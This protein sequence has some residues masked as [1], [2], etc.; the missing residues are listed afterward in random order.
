MGE[1]GQPMLEAIL[2]AY[3]TIQAPPQGECR[4]FAALLPVL[5]KQY[6]EAPF[7]R[8]ITE[9]GSMVMLTLNPAT[10][11]WTIIEITPDMIACIRASGNAM[12]PVPFVPDGTDL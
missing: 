10:G 7:L 5:R 11:T 9:K 8:G 2:A 3:I 6:K 1:A 12:E 4:P